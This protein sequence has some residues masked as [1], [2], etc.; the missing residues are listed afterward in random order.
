MFFPNFMSC[1]DFDHEQFDLAIVARKF[2][3]P[4]ALNP[5]QNLMMGVAMSVSIVLLWLTNVVRGDHILLIF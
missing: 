3:R 2:K 4:H 5:I 1:T